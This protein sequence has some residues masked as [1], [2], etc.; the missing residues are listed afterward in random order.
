VVG[1]I[2]NNLFKSF[3]I[4]SILF[5]FLHDSSQAA[6]QILAKPVFADV[7]PTSARS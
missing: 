2:P 7:L 5:K 1:S 3:Q 6:L 4:L